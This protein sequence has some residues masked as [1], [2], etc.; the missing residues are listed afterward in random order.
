VPL[1]AALDSAFHGTLRISVEGSRLAAYAIP[2]DEE[3]L[4]ARETLR[5]VASAST[6]RRRSRSRRDIN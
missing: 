5:L 6:A 1:I 4:I 2:T 3:Y